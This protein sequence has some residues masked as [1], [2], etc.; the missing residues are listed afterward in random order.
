VQYVVFKIKSFVTS[1]IVFWHFS[2]VL[3]CP[4][5]FP[6]KY[7]VLFIFTAICFVGG[8]RFILFTKVFIFIYAL[9]CPTRFPYHIQLLVKEGKTI[10]MPKENEQKTNDSPQNTMKNTTNRAPSWT[11]GRSHVLQNSKQS[12]LCKRHCDSCF[13]S[14]N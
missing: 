14:G 9:C 13:K 8:W 7:D 6:S 12:L 3:W 5:R 11:R 4:L 2:S 1:F 10:Q